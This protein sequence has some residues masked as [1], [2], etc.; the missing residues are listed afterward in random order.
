MYQHIFVPKDCSS[1]VTDITKLY[2][3]WKDWKRLKSNKILQTQIFKTLKQLLSFI[4]VVNRLVTK[5]CWKK[6]AA[7]EYAVMLSFAIPSYITKTN[8]P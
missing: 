1:K 4:Q 2:I 5:D 3:L 8:R 6:F 7:S